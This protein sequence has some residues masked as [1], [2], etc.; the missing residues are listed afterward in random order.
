MH[1]SCNTDGYMRRSI[2]AHSNRNFN[3]LIRFLL[4]VERLPYELFLLVGSV[5]AVLVAFTPL[6]LPVFV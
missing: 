1:G 2:L 5:V 6:F 3:V 4:H